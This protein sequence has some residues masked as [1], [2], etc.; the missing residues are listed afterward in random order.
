MSAPSG[1]PVDPRLIQDA[2]GLKGAWQGFRRR[3][4]QGELGSLPV[5]IGLS[6][7]W[8]IFYAANERFLSAVNLTN[9]MLQIAAMGT[10]SSGIVLVLLLGEIDL[11]AGAVSGLSASVMTILNVKQGWA[12]VPALLAGLATGAGIGL[13]HGLWMT[14]LRVPSFVVTLAGLLGWQ[15]ALLFVL[16]GTG[17]VNLN[18]RLITGLTGTF[19]GPEIA[20]PVAALIILAYVATVLV[21]RWKRAAAGLPQ[22]HLRSTVARVV[23]I[24]GAI[25][26]AIAVFTQDRGLPLAALIFAGF[27]LMLELVIRHTRFGRHVFAVGGN[28]EAARRAGIRVEAVR[29]AIFTLGST[30]A[31][32][33]GILASSRLLA[34]NQSSGSGDVLL[35]AIAAAVIGGTSLF[36]GR[37]SAWSAL[38]GA[39]VIGSI[40]NGMDLLALSSSVKFMVTGAVLLVAASI[41][42]LSR[43]G[44]QAAGRA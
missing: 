26:A 36:G 28:A 41:D 32:A 16:G 27:V 22:K 5:I 11:S 20:W 33:G 7:I 23:V 34:V 12:P 13:F 40:S 37:G 10:I 18:D 29:T 15:G 43:R 2:P 31:A 39:L 1:A 42:A 4:S 44:R 25:L 24:S 6:V 17:T 30:M 38:L 9:L 35:N 21:E 3:V 8:L 19:F 14:R